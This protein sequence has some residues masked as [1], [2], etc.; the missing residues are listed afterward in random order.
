MLAMRHAATAVA[1]AIRI[2]GLPAQYDLVSKYVL[3]K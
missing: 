3:I 2:V 1:I